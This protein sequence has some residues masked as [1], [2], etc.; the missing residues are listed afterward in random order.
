[1]ANSNPEMI[2]HRGR[3]YPVQGS[4]RVRGREYF[5]LRLLSRRMPV[6]TS[7]EAPSSHRTAVEE[8]W[9]ALNARRG[10][11]DDL[12]SLH[13]LP[14]EG[15][16]SQ[17]LRVLQ[18]L[19]RSTPFVPQIFDHQFQGD[20]VRI[21]TDWV[22][23]RTLAA[24]FEQ[25]KQ[26]TRSISP[27]EAFRLYR[28]LVQTLCGLHRSTGLV[29]GDVHPSNIV[30]RSRSTWLILIDFGSAWRTLES[31][32]VDGG[33]GQRAAWSAPEL[34]VHSTG[35]ERADQFSASVLLFQMLTGEI[36][37]SRLGGSAIRV[38][39]GSGRPLWQ[40][41]SQLASQRH[42]LTSTLWCQLDAFLQRTLSLQA[43]DRFETDAAWQQATTNLFQQ[44]N[45]PTPRSAGSLLDRLIRRCSRYR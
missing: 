13:V 19:A 7:T 5:L 36:P 40:P 9:L 35:D 23:G 20:Q 30:L 38:P 39:V 44:L 18:Q 28:G 33:D 26:R 15:L 37:Y 4:I 11:L 22:P 29:H 10:P 21:I 25:R 1:M 42:P 43:A 12:C 2:R 27:H 34:H 41:P 6:R 45:K 14:A 17:R 3:Y 8:R 16:G 32:T 31:T 24:Y